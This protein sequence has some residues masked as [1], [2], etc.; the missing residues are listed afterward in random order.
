MSED[1]IAPKSQQIDI[2]LYILII[3][4]K[5]FIIAICYYCAGRL[6]V[7]ESQ[8]HQ[9]QLKEFVKEPPPPPP[10]LE[11]KSKCIQSDSNSSN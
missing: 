2:N 7:N 11:T 9:K 6:Y 4:V 1:V 8:R 3:G 10:A 5:I